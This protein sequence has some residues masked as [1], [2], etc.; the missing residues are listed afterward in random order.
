MFLGNGLIMNMQPL[1]IIIYVSYKLHMLMITKLLNNTFVVI[2]FDFNDSSGIVR[3]KFMKV[4]SL[5]FEKE[6]K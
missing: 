1:G 2:L 5:L 4:V 3:R 6:L